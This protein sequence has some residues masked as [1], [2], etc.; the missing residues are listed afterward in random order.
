MTNMKYIKW[1]L[2][3]AAA[4][5]AL[6]QPVW[7]VTPAGA[8]AATGSA[9]ANTYGTVERGGTITAV[10]QENRTISVDGVSYPLS[11]GPVTVHSYGPAVPNIFKLKQGTKIRFN[12][13]WDTD[14]QDRVNEIWVKTPGGAA[15]Q[16]Q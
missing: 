16:K 14:G 9:L 1:T 7:A 3:S 6:S 10:N 15:T 2:F 11:F 8:G 13:V 4:F 12:T 5:L